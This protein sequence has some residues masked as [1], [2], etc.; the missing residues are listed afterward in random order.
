LGSARF[1][2]SVTAL[3]QALVGY[4]MPPESLFEA[5]T[6]DR[7]KAI[8][9]NQKCSSFGSGK[10][11][12]GNGYR[13][14]VLETYCSLCASR[15]LGDRT[16]LTF[17]FDSGSTTIH[18]PAVKR[19]RARLAEWQER[20][21]AACTDFEAADQPLHIR[22]V[23]ER[24]GVPLAGYLR[25]ERLGLTRIIR[26]RLGK[27]VLPDADSLWLDTSLKWRSARACRYR[28]GAGGPHDRSLLDLSGVLAMA[29]WHDDQLVI[30][31]D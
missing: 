7:S 21:A 6:S 17:D 15:F 4:Q 2:A 14:G 24:A 18:A 8:C 26:E 11:I 25:A 5:P 10:H 1:I 28:G 23:F 27:L 31:T 22:E 19:A 16:I 3:V 12:K 30:E 20:I 9:R 29:R 13:G